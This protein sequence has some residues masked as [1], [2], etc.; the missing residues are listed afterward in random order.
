MVVDARRPS[1]YGPLLSV[2]KRIDDVLSGADCSVAVLVGGAEGP[3]VELVLGPLARQAAVFV[4]P[5][6][7]PPTPSRPLKDGFS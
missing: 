5:E 1:S 3:D 6:G 4:D 7:R 2:L